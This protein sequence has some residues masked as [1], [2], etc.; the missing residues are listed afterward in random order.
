MFGTPES[1]A[2][3]R[4]LAGALLRRLER[5]KEGPLFLYTHFAEPHAPSQLGVPSDEFHHYLAAVAVADA[6]V[7]RV[8]R[9][10]EAHF[11]ERW[12]LIVTSGG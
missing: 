11:G 12:V 8:L 5:S 3:A 6:Q 9:F 2:P 10:L 4:M 7:G 1:A